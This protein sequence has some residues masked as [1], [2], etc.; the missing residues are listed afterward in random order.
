MR[1]KRIKCR[2]ESRG[3]PGRK[4]EKKTIEEGIFRASV[5]ENLI[6][7]RDSR[8]PYTLLNILLDNDD[9]INCESAEITFV[10]DLN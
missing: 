10:S 8:H 7:I 3:S 5:G 6:T 1:K 4:K 2:Q 9:K